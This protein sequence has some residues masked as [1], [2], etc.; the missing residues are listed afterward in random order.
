MS[1]FANATEE[2]SNSVEGYIR[3]TREGAETT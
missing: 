2:T 3:K 1:R